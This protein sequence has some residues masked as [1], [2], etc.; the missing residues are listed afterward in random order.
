MNRPDPMDEVPADLAAAFPD[1]GAAPAESTD[2]APTPAGL[3]ALHAALDAEGPA[4]R[5]AGLSTPL[6]W[7]AVL[8]FGVVVVAWVVLTRGR[9][10]LAVYP[11][12]RMAI[13]VGLLLAPLLFALTV[14]LRP[15]GKPLPAG[16]RRAVPMAFG[17]MAVLV[18][19]ALPVA[20]A[21]HPASLEGTGAA[22]WPRAGACFGFGL[23][24]AAVAVFGMGVLSR[25]SKWLPGS[26]GVWAAGMIGML[27]LYF[28]CPITHPEHLWAGHA[29]VI[30]P[31]LFAAWML[32]RRLDG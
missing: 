14:A 13:D 18:L 26:A 16:L 21:D 7:A 9:A 22:F 15:L 24:Y 10:D 28:H 30:I 32:R 23:A 8:G 2:A 27:A 25:G 5:I 11:G 4:D 12:V 31:V 3:D 19:I 1:L 20:H 17:A 6:R 29:T